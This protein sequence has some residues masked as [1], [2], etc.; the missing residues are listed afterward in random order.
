MTRPHIKIVIGA[1]VYN[2]NPGWLHTQEE[3]LNLLD[4]SKWAV[5][6]EKNS[7]SAI[8]AEHVWEH[9]TYEEGVQAAKLCHD[10]LMPSGYIRC[11]VPDGFFQDAEYQNM[12]QIGGPGPADHPASSHKIVHNYHTLQKLFVEAGF[13]VQ[14]LE[15]FDEQGIF[16]EQEWDGKDGVIFRSKRYDPRNQGESLKFPSLLV[17]AIKR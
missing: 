16:H 4:E 14:L 5:K 17:D 6:F 15:Y 13:E 9:L 1:G 3:E 8:L 2:N 12:V 10:F 11:A 7:I